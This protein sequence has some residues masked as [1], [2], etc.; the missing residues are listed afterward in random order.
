MANRPILDFR[1]T[2][3]LYGD[4][5]AAAVTGV[6]RSGMLL[7]GRYVQECEHSLAHLTAKRFALLFSSGTAAIESVMSYDARD[8]VTPTINFVSVPYVASK[9]GR[10]VR[11][12]PRVRP[13]GGPMA[14]LAET[15]HAQR[16][17]VALAGQAGDDYVQSVGPDDIEDASQCFMTITPH[18]MVGTFGLAGVYSFTFNKFVTAG[19]GGCVVTD[20]QELSEYLLRYR[21]FGRR[22]R[23]AER[24]VDHVGYNYRLSE[25]N[26]A[27][28]AVQLRH[29]HE[30]RERMKQLHET[31]AAGLAAAGLEIVT[32]DND[33]YTRVIVRVND[34]GVM[35]R[36]LAENY[37]IATP[38]PIMD[39]SITEVSG[40]SGSA[41]EGWD[42]LMCLPFWHGLTEEQISYV[43]SSVARL[44][45]DL[46][47]GSPG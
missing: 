1:P 32:D 28:L 30:T 43:S 16:W 17:Q 31:Y 47:T 22:D 6:L 25:V 8:V 27:M 15:D 2:Y 5:I 38:A 36:T 9:L 26:A 21:D 42:K 11:L 41:E 20:D 44:Q 12:R 13:L 10:R 23:R 4:E 45:A 33:N 39:Y 35:R 46:V 34:R 18:G 19:E 7:Q 29:A 40:F 3:L 24:P 14:G 37:G